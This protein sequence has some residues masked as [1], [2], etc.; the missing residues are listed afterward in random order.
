MKGEDIRLEHLLETMRQT[1][2]LSET[3]LEGIEYVPVQI[4]EGYC[5]ESMN[6]FCDVLE[7]YFKMAEAVEFLSTCGII[8]R[9][10]RGSELPQVFDSIVS[11]YENGRWLTVSDL[12]RTQLDPI[13]RAWKLELERSIFPYIV[14]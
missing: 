8:S 13:Y 5:E 6:L 9:G 12:I 10:E 1:V 7:A 14:S 11:H 4:Q 2:Y 3:C